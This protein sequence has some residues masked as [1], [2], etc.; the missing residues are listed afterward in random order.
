MRCHLQMCLKNIRIQTS[1]ALP[2]SS[3]IPRWRSCL[4]TSPE[5]AGSTSVWAGARREEPGRPSRGGNWGVRVTR[6]QPDTTLDLEECSYWGKSR[7][8]HERTTESSFNW[9]E[10]SQPVGVLQEK[11]NLVFPSDNCWL[12]RFKLIVV[13]PLQLWVFSLT[14]FSCSCK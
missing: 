6:W 10:S 7:W 1:S 5:V 3:P 2:F 4:W 14:D 13:Y 8:V 11:S 9:L 12:Q